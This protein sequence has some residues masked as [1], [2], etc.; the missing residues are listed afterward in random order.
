MRIVIRVQLPDPG[1]IDGNAGQCGTF[2]A[3]GSSSTILRWINGRLNQVAAKW[4]HIG[5]KCKM[6]LGV[7]DFGDKMWHFRPESDMK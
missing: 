7:G 6:G 5:M 2:F 4:Q 1:R 3:T